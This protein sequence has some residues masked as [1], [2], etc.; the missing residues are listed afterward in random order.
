MFVYDR[1][2]DIAAL[3]LQK[4]EL[5][6]VD[7]FDLN[8]VLKAKRDREGWCCVPVESLEVLRSALDG[9]LL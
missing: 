4:E 7:W 2:V 5:D 1:P 8:T 3:T 9:G 6:A